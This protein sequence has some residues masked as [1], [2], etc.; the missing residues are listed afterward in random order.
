[1]K[2]IILIILLALP[3]S[4][5]VTLDSARAK[6]VGNWVTELWG[7]ATFVE[8]PSAEDYDIGF[9]FGEERDN[10]SSTVPMGSYTWNG[11][12]KQLTWMTQL[13]NLPADGK[14]YFAPYVLPVKTISK[15]KVTDVIGWIPDIFQEPEIVSDLPQKITGI[16]GETVTFT[17][18]AEGEQLGYEWY[19]RTINID[20]TVQ[21]IYNEIGEIID[22]S[23]TYQ[24]SWNTPVKINGQ[25]T[26][27]YTTPNLSM[28]WDGWKVFVRVSN[29][30]GEAISRQCLLRIN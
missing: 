5:Q 2:T 16:E 19:R 18:Y 26:S 21:Y 29:A 12:L 9:L 6:Y 7:R 13:T 24:Y 30:L 28:T 3:I 4:A 20:S 17:I 10:Y 11:A 27:E 25:T 23:Y 15:F 8:T 22:S 1:M 14:Y